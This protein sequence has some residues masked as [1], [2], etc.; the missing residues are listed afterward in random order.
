MEI[1]YVFNLDNNGAVERKFGSLQVPNLTE[2]DLEYL[3]PFNLDLLNWIT[4]EY[5][6]KVVS[7]E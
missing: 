4:T 3:K 6:G 7:V 2:N 1:I 5:K